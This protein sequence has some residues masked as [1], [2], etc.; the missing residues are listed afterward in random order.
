MNTAGRPKK[1]TKRIVKVY[2][3]KCRLIFFN[4]AFFKCEMKLVVDAVFKRVKL[5]IT[6]LGWHIALSDLLN[7]GFVEIAIFN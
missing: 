5:E 3:Y 1:I 2:T 4:F 7:G 6:I